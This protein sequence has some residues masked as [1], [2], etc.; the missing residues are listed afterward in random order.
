M[1][2]LGPVISVSPW[3][4]VGGVS[5]GPRTGTPSPE[6]ACLC[7]LCQVVGTVPVLLQGGSKGDRRAV[8]GR[9][10]NGNDPSPGRVVRAGEGAVGGPVQAR[11]TPWRTQHLRMAPPAQRAPACLPA[12]AAGSVEDRQPPQPRPATAS[13]GLATPG[14]GDMFA[15]IC[16]RTRSPGTRLHSPQAPRPPWPGL[17][18]SHQHREVT[19]APLPTAGRAGWAQLSQQTPCAACIIGHLE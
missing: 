6:G 17:S 12:P 8:H 16:P 11:R 13:H 2:L 1:T 10:Q 15:G 19:R 9:L 5:G 4:L 18:L 3:G 14:A 7:V